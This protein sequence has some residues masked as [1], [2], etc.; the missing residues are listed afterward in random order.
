MAE[1]E[2][3]ELG[4][5]VEGLGRHG[6]AADGATGGGRS[7][8]GIHWGRGEWGVWSPPESGLG[9]ENE[10]LGGEWGDLFDG[11]PWPFWDSMYLILVWGFVFL[12][13]V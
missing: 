3:V 8:G 13:T 5:I 12:A 2:G 1:D 9:G 10:F 4:L 11:G 7:G 6:G